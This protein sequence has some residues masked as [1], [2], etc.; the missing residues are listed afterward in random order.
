MEGPSQM[1]VHQD[2][3]LILHSGYRHST[4]QPHNVRAIDPR[5]DRTLL[6]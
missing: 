4:R 5:S 1:D 3:V 2:L 6:P